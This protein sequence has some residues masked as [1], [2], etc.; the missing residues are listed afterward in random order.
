MYIHEDLKEGK[1]VESKVI[2]T[3]FVTI[4]NDITDLYG[5]VRELQTDQEVIRHLVENSTNTA[6]NL[7]DSLQDSIT[8]LETEKVVR[9]LYSTEDVIYPDNDTVTKALHETDFGRAILNINSSTRLFLTIDPDNASF[10]PIDNLTDYVDWFS[11][12]NRISNE[13]TEISE[14]DIKYAYDIDPN[15]LY[16]RRYT[17]DKD[18]IEKVDLIVDTN[19][20]LDSETINSIKL[21]PFP[22]GAIDIK[23]LSYGLNNTTGQY[24]VSPTGTQYSSVIQNARKIAFN[25]PDTEL[26]SIRLWLEQRNRRYSG[27]YSYFI[28][29]HQLIFE[30]NIYENTSYIGFQLT[31]ED[32]NISQINEFRTNF[33]DDS[34]DHP[35][36]YKIYKSLEDFDDINENYIYTSEN[37][38]NITAGNPLLLDN[39]YDT[40]YILVKIEQYTNGI[41]P[42]LKYI[43]I[44]W[45]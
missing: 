30:R 7:V 32:G 34:F 8:A 9:T 5:R 4:F 20:I 45:E 33:M 37:N 17:T 24:F 6:L 16:M 13:M 39:S 2:N 18:D 25:F 27:P 14:T 15:K 19:T 11:S 21:H 35:V 36:S 1:E 22:E 26:N 40:I 43:M 10:V 23:E 12:N 31:R 29:I 3:K 42:E 41:T 38:E 28:G 44:K